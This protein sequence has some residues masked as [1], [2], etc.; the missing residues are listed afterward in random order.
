MQL[1]QM[2]GEGWCIVKNSPIILSCLLFLYLG[3]VWANSKCLI[4]N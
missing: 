1:Q 3:G 4:K 2:N